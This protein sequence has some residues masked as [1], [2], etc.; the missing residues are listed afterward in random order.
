LRKKSFGAKLEGCFDVFVIAVRGKNE[1]LGARDLFENLSVASKPLSTGM[2][3]SI[4]TTVGRSFLVIST[5]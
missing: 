5:A 2:P 3:M 4:T 1:D